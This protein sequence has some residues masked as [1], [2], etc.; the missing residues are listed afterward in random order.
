MKH[1]LKTWLLAAFAIGSSVAYAQMPYNTNYSQQHFNSNSTTIKKQNASWD[2][3]LK[4]GDSNPFNWDDRYV[5]IALDPNSIPN[6][7]TFRYKCN[8]GIATNPD[9]YV[10]E[11][12]DNSTWT[13]V[14]SAVSPTSTIV[15]V[16]TDWYTASPITLSKSTR[17]IKLCYSGN[18]SGTFDNIKITDQSYVNDP[19]VND[20][21]I[22]SLDFGAGSISSGKA[23]LSFDVEWCNV[24]ALTVSSSNPELFS[25]SPASFGAK[26]KYGTQTVTVTYDR[27]KEIGDHSATITLTNGTITKKVNAFGSTTKR[28]QSIHWNAEL[29]ALNYVL[30]AGDSLTGSEIATADNEE[31]I[32]TYTSSDENVIA[33]SA[34]GTHL[35]AISNG[36]ATITAYAGGS[37]IY[38]ETTAAKQFTVTSQKKQTISW[39][40][41]LLGLKTTDA[42]RTISLNAQ[43]TSGGTI[44]YTIE[45][46]SSA[47]ITLGGENNATLTITGNA[48]QA[49]I[50]ATQAGGEINGETWISNSLRKLVKVRDPNSACDE[51]ALADRSFTFSEGHKT[52][53]AVQEFNL[54][55]K[56]TQLTFTARAGGTQYLWSEREP[57]YIEQ[58]ANFGSGL[59]WKLLASLTLGDSKNYGPYALNESAT[60]IRFRSGDYSEQ[61]VTN[62]L[63]PRKKEL[64]VSETAIRETAER[65]VRWSKTISVSRSNIDVVDISVTS[66]DVNC[67]FIIS[68]N[69]IGTDCA[70]RTTETFEVSIT[71]KEK[72][73]VYT[74]KI[75]ITD[76]K[77]QP[78][79][80]TI[81]LQITSVGFNQTISGFVLPETCYTT[82]T[83]APFTASASS[84]MPIVYLSSDSTIA[85]VENDQLIILQSG[86]VEITAYQAGDDRYSEVSASK[87]INI[88]RTPTQ[89]VTA[90]TASSLTIGQTLADAHLQGGEASVAGSFAWADSTITPEVGTQA[91]TVIFTP[92][93]EVLYASSTVQVEVTTSIEKHQ[94]AITWNQVLPQLYIGQTY[95]LE[96]SASGGLAVSFTST[97]ENIAYV[98]SNNTLITLAAGTITISATQEG[99]EFYDAAEP[100]AQ[101]ITILPPPATYGTYGMAFCQG[102]SLE[103][104]GVWYSEAK[105]IEVLSNQKNHLGGDSIINLS[106]TVL[107]T[108]SIEENLSIYRGAAET[109]QGTDLSL[110]AIGD[111]TLVAEY[112][113]EQGCDSVFTLHLTVVTP[114]TTYGKD[115]IVICTGTIAI[116]NGKTYKHATKESVLLSDPNMYGGDSIVELVIKML[117]TTRVKASKTILEGAN[118]T[119][120]DIDLSVIAPGD[121]TITVTYPSV[122]GCDS[123]YILYLTVTERIATGIHNANKTTDRVQK[124]LRDGQLYI[125]KGDDWYDLVG[126]KVK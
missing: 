98:D 28:Q 39:E 43:A 27:D 114:P 94:Q 13:K 22:S 30:N 55:G 37:D 41:D 44:T 65:S 38:A 17:Y 29:S 125:R 19:K 35:Y 78:T 47:C 32:L 97:D 40:Q 63:V 109:W 8:S 103:F 56:P 100:I 45:E 108:Y 67:P 14:W 3:G 42:G 122:F 58:Y 80:Q 105:Q 5:I 59:E 15:S 113:T 91:Y 83:I 1:I 18:Y 25:V 120:Q 60:K 57:I 9:W 101:E 104:E 102:D 85:Y 21:V 75:T 107:P 66:N 61:T 82:D 90:P 88:L 52:K 106:V 49:Y 53:H 116:Y 51:Y 96:A 72:N 12:S 124:I 79:T 123:T 71:P 20:A 117:P 126:N 10:S 87:T 81:N 4:L 77:A 86:Q 33:V 74:G 16:S 50:I 54:V 31:A 118:E 93:N 62:I 69:S 26:A 95:Q 112:R 115:T 89:I 2:G 110:F 36:N 46:G 99:N 6:Q 24:N 64:S 84:G 34:D 111:T 11:S 7:I 76:G 48:G 68:K 23:D 92:E 70:D 73:A 119:W 121:T